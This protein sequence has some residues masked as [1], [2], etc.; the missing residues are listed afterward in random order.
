MDNNINNISKYIKK[1]YKKSSKIKYIYED[2]KDDF[3]NSFDDSYDSDSDDDIMEYWQEILEKIIT[4]IIKKIPKLALN[5]DFQITKSQLYQTIITETR[6]NKKYRKIADH[7]KDIKKVSLKIINK[8]IKKFNKKIGKYGKEQKIETPIIQNNNYKE[9]ARIYEQLDLYE[10]NNNKECTIC[11]D[12][13]THKNFHVGTCNHVHCIDCIRN[14]ILKNIENSNVNIQCPNSN[15]K[16]LFSPKELSLILPNDQ[17]VKL[18]NISHAIKR[19]SNVMTIN[20][21]SK[22]FNWSLCKTCNNICIHSTDNYNESH[23]KCYVCENDDKISVMPQK[24]YTQPSVNKSDNKKNIKKTKKYMKK[25]NIKKCPKCGIMILK[26]GGCS[27]MRCKHCGK[28]FNWK[29]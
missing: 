18:S 1:I 23:I 22:T 29:Y 3:M 5:T 20:S 24:Q 15:C 21:N 17:L 19:N 27:D 9:K 28:S 12:D 14:H 7:I 2:F 11:F 25:K 13:I 26:N 4:K 8:Y 10:K 16:H 6:N